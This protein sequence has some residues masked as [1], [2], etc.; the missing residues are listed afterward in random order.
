MMSTINETIVTISRWVELSILGKATLML[1]LGLAFVKLA[2]RA[3]ASVRHLLLTAT[4]VTVFALPL[5]AL[6]APEVVIGVPVAQ[7]TVTETVT[8]PSTP[9]IVPAPAPLS[10]DLPGPVNVT[11]SWSAPSWIAMIRLVWL[12]GAILLATQLGVELWRLHRIRR[13]GL[14]W[15]ERREFMKSLSAESGIRRPVEV[16]LHEG[17]LAP[18]TYGIWRPAILLPYEASEW[19]EADLTRA[20]VHE[21]EHVRRSDW[22]IQLAARAT[23]AFY[24]FHPLVWVAFRGLSLQAERACDDAVVRGAERTEYAEQL[25]LLA[26][27]LSKAQTQGALGMANRSDLSTRVSALL[28]ASQR[29]GRAGFLAAAGAL[30]A[31]VI[32]LATIAP[33]RAVAQSR[34]STNEIEQ[35]V[36]QAKDA[37]A[38][39]DSLRTQKRI[40]SALDRA[41]LEAA[42]EGDIPG[43]EELISKGANVNRA[44]DG[45][46][47]PLIAAAREGR[48]DAVRLLLDRGADPNLA[49][50][51]DGNALIMAAR[52]GRAEVVSVL[53]DRGAS[54][55]QIVPGDENALI[56]ASGRGHLDV[57]KL[58]VAR[59]ADVNARAWADAGVFSVELDGQ[60]KLIDLKS[61][62]ELTYRE[63][64]AKRLTKGDWRTPLGQARISGHQEIV[65]FLIAAGARE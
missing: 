3:R 55:D 11:A 53:L 19:S 65:A 26:G 42:E 21:L 58:L 48:L 28:D 52:E 4:F 9:R 23:C 56:Q 40:S 1:V 60:G 8:I 12:A 54:I 41:L 49:V 2:G 13:D 59:G 46:G 22:A 64:G 24:W 17:I 14:P 25:V 63:I 47:S 31:A 39:S 16:L 29:R 62:K 43:I 44:I 6:T 61:G 50:Q 37:A 35:I 51:G 27:R 57:V 18:L 15:T 33:V 34:K 32:V 10:V 45:D 7:A 38:L 36:Q 20:I 5:I 30:A